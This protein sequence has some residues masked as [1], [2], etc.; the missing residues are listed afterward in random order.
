MGAPQP[1][2]VRGSCSWLVVQKRREAMRFAVPWSVNRSLNALFYFHTRGTVIGRGFFNVGAH[3]QLHRLAT[4]R[5]GA[6]RVRLIRAVSLS[7]SNEG[8]LPNASVT[9]WEQSELCKKCRAG[10]PRRSNSAPVSCRSTAAHK[11]G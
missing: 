2:M 4:R 7:A 10:F 6:E 3:L 5:T 8:W 1:G 9:L 11:A